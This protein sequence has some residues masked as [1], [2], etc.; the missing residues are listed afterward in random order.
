M[1]AAELASDG[2]AK[3]ASLFVTNGRILAATGLSS[4]AL[5]YQLFEGIPRCPRCRIDE[6]TPDSNPLV[7]A[8][9]RARAVV[10]ATGVADTAGFLEVPADSTITVGHDL[11]VQISPID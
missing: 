6:R 5:T 4:G 8:H 10:L 1:E 3:S 11:Q 7:R 2:K 9:R